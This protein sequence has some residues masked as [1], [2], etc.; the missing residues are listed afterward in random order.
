MG[1]P[2]ER[3]LEHDDVVAPDTVPKDSAVEDTALE[4]N[5]TVTED[6]AHSDV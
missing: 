6:H 3:L 1:S 5:A 4:D 2:S